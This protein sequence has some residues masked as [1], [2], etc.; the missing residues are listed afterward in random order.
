MGNMNDNF[1]DFPNANDN[2]D[3]ELDFDWLNDADESGTPVSSGGTGVTGE[4]DWLN[5][6]DDEDSIASSGGDDGASFEWDTPSDDSALPTSN[7]GDDIDFEWESPSD[8]SVLPT[9]DDGDIDTFD[10]HMNEE[11]DELSA[12]DEPETEDSPRE[13]GV[14]KLK[15]NN[16]D[17]IEATI[18]E[19]EKADFGDTGELLDWMA[20]SDNLEDEPDDSEPASQLPDWL[21]GMSIPDATD[22]EIEAARRDVGFDDVDDDFAEATPN[23]DLPSW[24]DSADDFGEESVLESESLATDDE[25]SWLDAVDDV[26]EGSHEATLMS[27]PDVEDELDSLIDSFDDDPLP[28][29]DWLKP[30]GDLDE[31]AADDS[32]LPSTG[33]LDEEVVN[34]DSWLS[35]T[36]ELDE[37]VVNDDSWLPSTG[38]LDTDDSWLSSTGELNNELGESSDAIDELSNEIDDFDE[39]PDELEENTSEAISNDMPDWIA[40]MK[41]PES[42]SNDDADAVDIDFDMLFDDAPV[43]NSDILQIDEP[44]SADVNETE[45]IAD[46]FGDDFDL[47]EFLEFSDEADEADDAR[48]TAELD[49]VLANL[50]ST[51]ELIESDNDMS[52]GGLFDD[53]G[54]DNDDMAWLNDATNEPVIEEMPV[55]ESESVSLDDFDWLDEDNIP[56]DDSPVVPD[57]DMDDALESLL[58]DF[59]DD[60]ALEIDSSVGLEGDDN[61]DMAWLADA[62]EFDAPLNETVEDM[63]EESAN[64]F[65]WEEEADPNALPDWL[66]TLDGAE[67]AVESQSADDDDVSALLAE[68]DDSGLDGFDLDGDDIGDM[69]ALLAQ[70]EAMGDD[71]VAFEEEDIDLDAFLDSIDDGETDLVVA[72]PTNLDNIFENDFL[73]LD[74]N[75]PI[76]ENAEIPE[77]APEWLRQLSEKDDANTAAALVRQ[78]DDRPVEELSDRL[79]VL[80]QKG[81]DIGTTEPVSE[82]DAKEADS[83]IDSVLPD[84]AEHLDIPKMPTSGTDTTLNTETEVDLNRKQQRQLALLESLIGSTMPTNQPQPR[85]RLRLRRLSVP[86]GIPAFRWLMVSLLILGILIPFVA[87]VNIGTPPPNRFSVGTTEYEAFFR[88]ETLRPDNLVLVAVEYS[89]TSAG[90]LD[91]LTRA[92]IAHI[93][94]KGAR[95][96]IV[97]SDVIGLSRAENIAE[98]LTSVSVRNRAYYPIRYI[99]GG[100]IGLR[101]ISTTPNRIFSVDTHGQ[102]T[103]LRINSLDDFALGIIIAENVESMRGWM[104]QIAP[105]TEMNWIVATGQSAAP[106][107]Q[108]YTDSVESVGGLLVGY[109]DAFT[110]GAFISPSAQTVPTTDNDSEAVP[111]QSTPIPQPTEIPNEPSS[112]PTE[113]TSIA[114]PTEELPVESENEPTVEPTIEISTD[115]TSVESTEIIPEPTVDTPTETPEVEAPAQDAFVRVGTVNSTGAINIRS[116]AGTTFNAIGALQGGTQVPIIDEAVAD[117]GVLWYQ[118]ELPDGST[119]WVANFLL[120]VELVP[121]SDVNSDGASLEPSTRLAMPLFVPLAQTDTE[122]EVTETP[123]PPTATPIPTSTPSPTPFIAE[124]SYESPSQNDDQWQAMTSGLLVAIAMIVVANLFYLVRA[125]MRRGN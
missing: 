45:S 11:S 55:D 38:E 93:M 33:E 20:E 102:P 117:D 39:F 101:E 100:T 40:D 9:G 116:G 7:D 22:D 57:E 29:A 56:V 51:P 106:L 61:D 112:E 119:G 122:A 88:V 5:V 19:A 18:L 48:S 53:F 41:P 109:E 121:A 65:D 62:S 21:S 17:S 108:T 71:N 24:L 44:L 3:D 79:M 13:D 82:T 25:P 95:P 110:Y 111:V 90:E 52:S 85:R 84:V 35:S 75:A 31:L 103:G 30:T 77:D 60:F 14:G 86:Q 125:F 114:Q 104:E 80:R 26:M 6:S 120:I 16:M 87:D 63:V 32:W 34:D 92:L 83:A 123:S 1:N 46:D 69:D 89:A 66:D 76:Q 12:I 91:E 81:L 70:V 118:I 78:Q 96:V 10:W 42:V 113:D 73:A 27:R 59:D 43:P 37:E 72:A 28:D 67:L 115:D 124:V 8:D 97:S 54:D 2:D 15:R 68:L 50:E 105:L 94:Q 36:G 23:E 47:D 99:T 58:T 107:V 98:T 49:N 74:E 64:D 4:L